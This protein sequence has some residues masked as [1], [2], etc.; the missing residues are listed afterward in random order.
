MPKKQN[1]EKG[2]LQCQAQYRALVR[3]LL[4]IG[5]IWPG[6]LQSRMLTCGRPRCACHEDPEKRH[7]P[8]WYWTTKK[9][10]KTLSKKLTPEDAEIIKPWIENRKKI[11]TTLRRMRQISENVHSLMLRKPNNI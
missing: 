2:L 1:P 9:E 6:T 3:T 7:G 11:D 8:Y 10:G 4:D 5:F